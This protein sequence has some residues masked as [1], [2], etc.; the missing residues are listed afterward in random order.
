MTGKPYPIKALIVAG[1]NPMT[2]WPNTFGIAKALE[3]LE[4]VVV[5]DP[6][7][8]RTAELAHIALPAATCFEKT[9]LRQGLSL[10]QAVIEPLHECKTDFEFWVTLARK[11]GYEEYF[12]WKSVEEFMEFELESS[13]IKLEDFRD[14]GVVP[15]QYKGEKFKTPSG[16]VELY[17][18][19]FSDGGYEPL[20]LFKEPKPSATSGDD[21]AREYPLSLICGSRML[22]YTHSRYRNVP[23]L[24]R[25]VPEPYVQIHPE[26]ARKLGVTNNQRVLVE[27]PK[28]KVLIK[29]YITEKIHPKVVYIPDGGDTAGWAESGM[30]FLTEDKVSDPISGDHPSHSMVCRISRID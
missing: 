25:M 17:S 8:T 12:P 15:L 19:A 18:E 16:K 7:M 14:K 3:S 5:M 6:F 13:G 24:N 11:T 23:S 28:G 26:T 1:A 27:T 10:M 21:L 20:P 30:N 29:P 22:E 9:Q 2:Q 4:L